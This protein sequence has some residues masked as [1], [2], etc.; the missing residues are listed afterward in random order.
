MVLMPNR[1][2]KGYDSINDLMY[3]TQ[4]AQYIAWRVSKELVLEIKEEIIEID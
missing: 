4:V 2:R 3:Q 1:E